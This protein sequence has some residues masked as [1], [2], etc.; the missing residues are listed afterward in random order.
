MNSVDTYSLSP[1]GTCGSLQHKPQFVKKHE[2]GNGIK[3]KHAK[4][5][6]LINR[7]GA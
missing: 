7:P 6:F 1:W 2:N 3:V 5:K 4:L